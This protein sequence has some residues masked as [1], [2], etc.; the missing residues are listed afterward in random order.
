MKLTLKT[1]PKK[2]PINAEE[3]KAMVGLETDQDQFD[4]LLEGLISAAVDQFEMDT[5]IRLMEQTWLQYF[6]DW[7]LEDDFMELAYP[8]LISVA[9]IKYTNSAEEQ[10]TW[11]SANYVL[12]I[13]SK[14]GR[15]FLGYSSDWPSVTLTPRSDAIEVE[16][17]CGYENSDNVPYDIKNTLKLLVEFWFT[18]RAEGNSKIPSYITSAI[19]KHRIYSL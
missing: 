13:A 16:Y 11:A 6:S 9:T 3:V 12:D 2:Q 5:N 8:P 17:V 15:V 4:G 1:A 7:P 19:Q 14:P 10:S 18:N